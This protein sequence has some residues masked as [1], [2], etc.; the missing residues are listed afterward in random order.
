METNPKKLWNVEPYFNHPQKRNYHKQSP[1]YQN[2]GTLQIPARDLIMNR[3]FDYSY[4][5][6][7]LFYD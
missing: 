4:V 6:L 5:K 2:Y 7:G 3:W 1:P